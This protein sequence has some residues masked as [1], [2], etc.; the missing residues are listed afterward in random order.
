MRRGR[1]GADPAP[2]A[3]PIHLDTPHSFQE[4]A[5]ELVSRTP[6]PPSRA[7]IGAD[8]ALRT[9]SYSRTPTFT[10]STTNP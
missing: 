6:L 3:T 10:L 7:S 4:R 2:A 8:D 1:V 5:A 9:G